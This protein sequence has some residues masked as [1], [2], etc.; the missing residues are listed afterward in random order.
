MNWFSSEFNEEQKK[1]IRDEIRKANNQLASGIMDDVMEEIN[2]VRDE[3]DETRNE[4]RDETDVIRSEILEELFKINELKT[5]LLE[6]VD[7][8]V[9]REIEKAFDTDNIISIV[10]KYSLKNDIDNKWKIISKQ[11]QD[12]DDCLVVEYDGNSVVEFDRY[13]KLTFGNAGSA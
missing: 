1:F 12:G 11:N 3:M 2:E 10:L 9:E 6:R 8:S 5:E 13:G 7:E 4:I